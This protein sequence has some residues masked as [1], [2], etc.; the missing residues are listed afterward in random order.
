MRASTPTRT[1]GWLRWPDF[2][3][4]EMS[5]SGA[6]SLS[7][8][9]SGRRPDLAAFVISLESPK[10]GRAVREGRGPRKSSSRDFV[11]RI[12]KTK[13]NKKPARPVVTR[14]GVCCSGGGS[15]SAI[16]FGVSKSTVRALLSPLCPRR[17]LFVRSLR[18]HGAEFHG[19]GCFA[20]P[21]LVPGT[22]RRETV[23]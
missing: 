14:T 17:P 7:L 8:P 2:A 10:T 6:A 5:L 13:Q 22:R 19:S 11:S 1:Q 4:G 15:D 20:G 18:T 12:G 9:G 23:L 16:L 21:L 3:R